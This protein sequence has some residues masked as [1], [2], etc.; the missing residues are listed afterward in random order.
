MVPLRLAVAVVPDDAGLNP[1]EPGLRIELEEPGGV[2]RP[3][4]HDRRVAALARKAG[5]TSPGQHRQIVAAAGRNG[6]HH[7]VHGPRDDHSDRHVA[8][9]RPIGRVQR[10]GAG[11]EPDLTFDVAFELIQQRQR[12]VRV[13]A[14]QAGGGRSSC[15][16]QSK[17]AH[18]RWELP[19]PQGAKRWRRA[20][21]WLG[22][23][24]VTENADAGSLGWA[25]AAGDERKEP[26]WTLIWCSKGEGSRASGWWE[27][28]P[29]W[30]NGATRSIGWRGPRPGPSWARC[31]RRGWT[32]QRFRT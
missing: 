18:T 14:R 24:A 7:V 2:L 30:R 9:V 17:W 28:S 22:D 19:G 6:G 3:V 5:P 25:T 1:S 32:P 15:R 11:I 20:P 4:D 8:V 26:T 16:G 27:R 12:L 10:A 21:A 13:N 31:W 23:A 29:S